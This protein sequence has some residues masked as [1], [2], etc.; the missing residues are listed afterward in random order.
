M[1]HLCPA[2]FLFL[3]SL[4]LTDPSKFCFSNSSFVCIFFFFLCSLGSFCLSNFSWMEAGPC[5]AYVFP[6]GDPVA[7]SH[8]TTCGLS[9]L[10]LPSRQTLFLFVLWPLS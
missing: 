10:S 2:S 8:A 7:G 5:F 1:S 9:S 3:I 6:L 4:N